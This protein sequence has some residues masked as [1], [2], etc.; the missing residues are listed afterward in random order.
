MQGTHVRLSWPT[1]PP[2]KARERQAHKS[3]GPVVARNLNPM[4]R[5]G[6]T[7]VVVVAVGAA[8]HTGKLHPR[9]FSHSPKARRKYA[10]KAG[11]GPKEREAATK[12]VPA[13]RRLQANELPDTSA[14]TERKP[15]AGSPWNASPLNFVIAGP[16]VPSRALLL[17]LHLYSILAASISSIDRA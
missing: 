17:S 15:F 2:S 8:Q 1:R 14:A 3:G 6:G 13:L 5:V 11:R 16:F 9:S 7:V 12:S 4:V 10:G